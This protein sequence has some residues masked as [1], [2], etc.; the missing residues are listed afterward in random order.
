[1]GAGDLPLSAMVG[2]QVPFRRKHRSRDRIK[3]GDRKTRTGF[4]MKGKEVRVKQ[5][6]VTFGPLEHLSYLI[7][8]GREGGGLQLYFLCLN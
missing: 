7:L 5:S 4:L 1:M 2:C 8:E 6:G 3:D